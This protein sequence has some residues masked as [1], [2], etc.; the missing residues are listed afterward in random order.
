MTATDNRNALK[1]IAEQADEA[2]DVAE[3]ALLF[4]AMELPTSELSFYRD[5]LR[6]ISDAVSDCVVQKSGWTCIAKHAQVLRG[7]GILL[8]PSF[9]S[10]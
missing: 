10:N 6:A 8:L 9:I 1:H 7:L 3:A 2:I 4:A 5:H